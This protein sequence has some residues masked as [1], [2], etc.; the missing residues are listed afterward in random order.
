VLKILSTIILITSL[1]A[2]SYIAGE[3]QRGPGHITEQ[4]AAYIAKVYIEKNNLFWG[5]PIRERAM[6]KDFWFYY[7]TP[8][9][10]SKR[11]GGRV[12]IVDTKT[13]KVSIPPRL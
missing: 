4:Q 8:S 6:K 12:L 9:E 11:I 10:E 1:F 5:D 13:G 7:D 2:C 3:T